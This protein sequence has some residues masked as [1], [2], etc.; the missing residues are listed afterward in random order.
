MDDLAIEAKKRNHRRRSKQLEPA[1]WGTVDSGAIADFVLFAQAVDGAVR[2][3]RSRDGATYSLGFYIGDE[4]F[5]EWIRN[6][7]DRDASFRDLLAELAEDYGTP[8]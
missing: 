4:R 8:I 2:F 6:D 7:V 1:D 3:G 5:T